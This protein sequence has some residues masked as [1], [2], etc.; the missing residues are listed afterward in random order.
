[1]NGVFL[2]GAADPRTT[3]PTTRYLSR[4]RPQASMIS[5]GVGE[6]VPNHSHLPLVGLLTLTQAALGMLLASLVSLARFDGGMTSATL[7]A[8]AALAGL[9]ASVAHL[10]RP[11]YGFRVFLGVRTS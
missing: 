4:N 5:A 1:A 2:V 8:L 3:L 11:L 7:A 9:T 10:G 6:L